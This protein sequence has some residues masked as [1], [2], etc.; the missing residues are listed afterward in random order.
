MAK[1]KARIRKQ[2][3]VCQVCGCSDVNKLTVH[4]VLSRSLNEELQAEDKNLVLLCHGC[5]DYLHD[6]IQP[7]RGLAHNECDFI[8]LIMLYAHRGN[9]SK[10]NKKIFMR[11]VL[12]KAKSGYYDSNLI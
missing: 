11:D 1:W 10:W 6:V 4:H 12:A 5:H 9:K 7:L 2:Q 8:S 3:R